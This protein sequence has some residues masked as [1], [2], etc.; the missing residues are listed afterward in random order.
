M[1]VFQVWDHRI[2][3]YTFVA[4]KS[5]RVNTFKNSA[6]EVLRKTVDYLKPLGKIVTEEE[7]KVMVRMELRLD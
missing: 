2:C 6:G 5:S 7:A 3:S 4:G 1:L